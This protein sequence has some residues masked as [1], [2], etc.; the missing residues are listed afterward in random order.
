[1][2]ANS[3]ISLIESRVKGKEDALIEAYIMAGPTA[4]KV[5]MGVS[6]A[7]WEV[8]FDYLVFEHNMLYKA[9]TDSGDF[10]IDAFVK[11][12][13][14]HVREILDAKDAK[15][16]SVIEQIFDFIAISNDALYAHVLQHRSKYMTAFRAR[17]GD[18]TRKVLGIWKEKYDENWERILNVL[19]N[20]CC[21]AIFTQN[22]FEHGLKAFSM[23]VNGEREHR[24]LVKHEF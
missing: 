4:T 3:K 19:L 6:A 10:F 20:A 21:D 17:G 11:F 1:M 8:V 15:Y 9:V 13:M 24:P 7:E 18:F 22:T 12:G 14:S 5:S 2:D 16:D 23:I